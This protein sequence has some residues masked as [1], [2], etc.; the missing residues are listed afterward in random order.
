LNS[1]GVDLDLN[2]SFRYAIF[3][4][5]I[6]VAGVLLYVTSA[7]S[8]LAYNDSSLGL[9]VLLVFSFSIPAI[10]VQIV[11]FNFFNAT[12]Q[13]S[14]ELL[15]TWVFNFFVIL[16]GAVLVLL[17]LDS[18]VIYFV[19][20][21]VVL[22]WLFVVAAF[23]IFSR[24]INLYISKLQYLQS[25]PTKEYTVYFFRGLPLALCF[26]GESLLFFI[27]SFVSKSLGDA[28]LSAYQASLHF[29]SIIYMISIGVGNATG[30]VAARHYERKDFSSL[31][32]TYNQGVKFGLVI[33]T[34]LLFACFFLREN[35]SIV[36]TS[37]V[38]VRKSIESNIIVSIPFLIFEYVYIVTRMTLRSMGDFWVPT[39][40]TILS[41]NILGLA[42]SMYLLSSYEYSVN[43]IF[44]ALVFCSF[45]LML[46]LFWRLVSILKRHYHLALA[47]DSNV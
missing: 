25:V 12:K 42:L 20:A 19:S 40:F 26:G 41:L 29:L 46:F 18:N 31:R 43:S 6:I 34:P 5:C 47:A 7:S 30:I 28:S 1:S 14:Y 38:V 8:S 44:I 27:L 11:I 4:G 35:I 32:K 15:Y 45:I 13:T 9:E 2:I 37:D 33:L 10:Y 39:L 16:V 36:Y 23:I 24:K 22:R 21:Y 3:F 17:E